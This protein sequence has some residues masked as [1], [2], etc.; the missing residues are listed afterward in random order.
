MKINIIKSLSIIFIICLFSFLIVVNLSKPRV[1]ILHSYSLDYSWVRDINKGLIRIFHDRPY[2]FRWHYMDTKRHPSQ[3]Y[4]Q[5]AGD[6]AKAIIRNWKPDILIAI[7]DNAQQ[8]VARNFLNSSSMKIVFTGVNASLNEYE[9]D[10]AQNVTGILERIPFKA[11]KE[12]FLQLLPKN[13]TR[14][15]HISD[16]STSSHFIH[17][18]L[19]E[20]EWEPLKLVKS[21]Q[22]ET[23]DEWKKGIDIAEQI[24]DVLLITHYHTIK[25][26]R[27]DKS[28]IPPKKIIQLTEPLL[29]IPS[30]GCW[31]FFVEDG[32]MM[33]LAV[34]PYEQG[35]EAAKMTVEIIENRKS[36]SQIPIKISIQYV[37]YVRGNMIKSRNMVLPQML[38]AFAR[39]TNHFYE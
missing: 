39:A 6:T 4:K 27:T 32:G 16:N 30:I 29:K 37:V 33:A 2:S 12:V 3:E 14:I 9:Y 5:K 23:L 25:E 28:I 38:E 22:C 34:S 10:K 8:Y 35:E 20:M 17:K 31:G 15:V 11:F 13:K 36:P 18:E 19:E 21:F 7:D 26:K 24:G 1:F